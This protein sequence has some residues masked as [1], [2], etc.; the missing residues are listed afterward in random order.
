MTLLPKLL[1]FKKLEED[2]GEYV[3]PNE[4]HLKTRAILTFVRQ[5]VGDQ[6]DEGEVEIYHE[7][8]STLNLAV[9]APEDLTGDPEG[10]EGA[11]EVVETFEE[12]EVI[13][14]PRSM[15]YVEE[16]GAFLVLEA[17]PPEQVEL[18]DHF[19]GDGEPVLSVSQG[20]HLRA[21][22]P[23][24]PDLKEQ[25]EELVEAEGIELPES[26]EEPT[27]ED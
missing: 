8:R 7:A 3:L 20:R 26:G 24:H 23:T 2:W 11:P 13:R 27:A 16:T 6:E 4:I 25:L 5:R 14:N 15:Y 22:E 18:T 1:R 12:L 19:D 9:L 10:N 17:E 21:T